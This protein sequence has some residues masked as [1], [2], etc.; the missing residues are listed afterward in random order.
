MG[1]RRGLLGDDDPVRAAQLTVVTGW[2]KLCQAAG[3]VALSASG[4]LAVLY[5]P[6][7]HDEPPDGMDDM[8]EAIE[9]LTNARPGAA[10]ASQR[11]GDA[12]RRLKARPMGGKRLVMDG[13]TG[14]VARWRTV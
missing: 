1:A 13:K 2:N 12:L 6:P 11:M 5:P 4:A 10:P 7:R 9:H 3:Q 14:G 8:R